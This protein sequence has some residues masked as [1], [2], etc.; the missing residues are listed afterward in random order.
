MMAE[1]PKAQDGEVSQD[2]SSPPNCSAKSQ[3]VAKYASRYCL[4]AL[5]AANG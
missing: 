2:G 1:L 4:C 5:R 3:A